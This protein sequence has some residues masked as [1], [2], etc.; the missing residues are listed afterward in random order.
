MKRQIDLQKAGEAEAFGVLALRGRC[1]HRRG[2]G[3]GEP[4]TPA[5]SRALAEMARSLIE[6]ARHAGAA[7]GTVTIGD[8]SLDLR[9]SGLKEVLSIKSAV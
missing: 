9:T 2:E 1:R 4:F 6:A 7:N 5:Q 3:N 8:I